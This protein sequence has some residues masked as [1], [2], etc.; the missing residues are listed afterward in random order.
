MGSQIQRGALQ[1]RQGV[2]WYHQFRV[3]PLPPRDKCVHDCFRLHARL[4]TDD[5]EGGGAV[6]D[7]SRRRQRHSVPRFG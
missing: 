3:R 4:E 2:R 1:G 5:P 7:E 6:R